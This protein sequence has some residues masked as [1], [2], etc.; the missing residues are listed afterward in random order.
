MESGNGGAARFKTRRKD[1]FFFNCFNT[2]RKFPKCQ[3]LDAFFKRDVLQD[4]LGPY[5]LSGFKEHHVTI[6]G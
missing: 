2:E 6:G 1:F 4:G 5:A 3:F